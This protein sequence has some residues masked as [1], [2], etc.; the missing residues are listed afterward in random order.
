MYKSQGFQQIIEDIE[1]KSQSLES[2]SKVINCIVTFNDRLPLELGI[3]SLS[4]SQLAIQKIVGKTKVLNDTDPSG[5]RCY[6]GIK[7]YGRLILTITPPLIEDKDRII[8]TITLD[9]KDL[10][11]IAY[12]TNQLFL[13][14]KLCWEEARS[15][16]K[17]A[18]ERGMLAE[19]LESVESMIDHIDPILIYVEEETFS[20][21]GK[22]NNLIEG[23][24]DN[25]NCLFSR[26][27]TLHLE[28]WKAE[29][30]L[31]IFCMEM[32][33]RSG[34][35]GEEFNGSQLTPP[36]L[37]EHFKKRLRTYS[38]LLNI[39]SAQPESI[40]EFALL[41]KS[42]K[43]QLRQTNVVYRWVNGLNF[44]K[45]EHFIKKTEFHASRNLIVETLRLNDHL[46]V[47]FIQ[48]MSLYELCR[49]G[50]KNWVSQYK[51][52]GFQVGEKI[53]QLLQLIVQSATHFLNA[54][55]GMTRGFRSLI[56]FQKSI[57]ND[58]VLSACQWPLEDYYCCVVPSKSFQNAMEGKGKLLFSILNAISK[59]MEYNSWHY[60]PGHF[61]YSKVPADRHFYFPPAMP[62][63]AEWSNQHHAGH[64]LANVLYSIRFPVPLRYQNKIF[65][66][67]SDLRFMRRSGTPFSLDD[68]KIAGRYAHILEMFIQALCDTI[69]EEKIDIKISAFTKDW[70]EL[71]Y[72]PK[73]EVVS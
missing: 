20:V 67:M 48:G 9:K 71:N 13:E 30:Q 1:G 38:E 14:N 46:G 66:G 37:I 44:Y 31:F 11:A 69:S 36:I 45:E 70:Y 18:L 47:S 26:L 50:L 58:D 65:P 62:D 63:T 4:Y 29:E 56:A 52:D 35:R 8:G 32:L 22:H 25:E 43:D 72:T 60:M 51:G 40:E 16:L 24:N 55:I 21:F 6:V 33:R 12:E 57:N 49:E 5:N 19:I 54:D 39:S 23:R 61:L 64:I 41:L 15:F 68:L 34:A 17:G 10:D 73:Y 42:L 27:K 53:E 3:R 2:L 28:D 7:S 59:R